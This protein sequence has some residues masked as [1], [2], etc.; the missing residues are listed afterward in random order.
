MVNVLVLCDDFWHPAEVIQK[1]LKSLDGGEFR[2]DFVMA[3]KDILTP[4]RIAEYQVIVCAKANQFSSSNPNPWFDEGVNE[5]MP[6]D[7][8]A[9]LRQGG[10]FLALH[11]GNNGKK[12]EPYADFVGNYFVK[13]PPR[14]TVN[15]RV[16]AEHPI[17][18]GISDF[19]LRD[20]H[21][22]IVLTAADAEVILRSSS[23]KGGDQV[24]GYV[25]SIGKGRLAALTPGHILDN[26]YD[27][28]YIALIRSAIRWCAGKI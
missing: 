1:G 11:A 16:V 5:V 15:L 3:A 20:E 10:G 25:R 24:A 7:F 9:Y 2:L 19:C 17:T 14:C 22:E 12:D 4:A 21:Y 18:K 6:R 23:E 26:Y 28:H 8:E 27:E 13:H